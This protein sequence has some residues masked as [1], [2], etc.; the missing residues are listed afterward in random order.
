MTPEVIRL[1][2]ALARAIQGLQFYA[3]EK[4]YSEGFSYHYDWVTKIESDRGAVAQRVLKE[5]DDYEKGILL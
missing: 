3:D 4:T 2:A 1:N 5:I